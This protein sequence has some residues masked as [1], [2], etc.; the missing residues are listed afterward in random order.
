MTRL[1]YSR[2]QRLERQLQVVSAATTTAADQQ[3]LR[4]IEAARRRLA[5]YRK[6]DTG[7]RR[8]E[9]A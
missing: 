7:P 3:L 6:S 9:A 1:N 5:E 4:R 8:E 2:L